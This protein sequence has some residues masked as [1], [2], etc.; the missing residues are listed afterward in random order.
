LGTVPAGGVTGVLLGL[1]G[2]VVP[3]PVEMVP[4]NVL[5]MGPNFIL[6]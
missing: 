6:E 5:L 1:V 2:A 3:V 4:V